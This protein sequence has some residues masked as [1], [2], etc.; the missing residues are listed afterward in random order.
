MEV[1]PTSRSTW[2]DAEVPTLAGPGPYLARANSRA[3]CRGPYNFGGFSD[4]HHAAMPAYG[5]MAV[6]PLVTVC[7]AR[8]LRVT[9]Q[10][11]A[12]KREYGT[13]VNHESGQT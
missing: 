13:S 7:A 1:T 3:Q 12:R 6:A 9:L 11:I 4:G 10:K 2:H 5:G 8:R